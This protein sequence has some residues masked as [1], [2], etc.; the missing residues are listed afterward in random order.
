MQ[1]LLD[2]VF[3]RPN[4]M[5]FSPGWPA[6]AGYGR[7]AKTV[8]REAIETNV[9]RAIIN[10]WLRHGVEVITLLRQCLPMSPITSPPAAKKLARSAVGRC[11]AAATRH[12]FAALL[13]HV[14]E[15]GVVALETSSTALHERAGRPARLTVI[16]NVRESATGPVLVNAWRSLAEHRWMW[17]LNAVD[18]GWPVNTLELAFTLSSKRQT[19]GL[20]FS[21]RAQGL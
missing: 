6:S 14:M 5:W 13:Y 10:A 9:V 16:F 15:N 3:A 4:H 2:A 11:C 1:P 19:G 12:G 17:L 7:A 8:I 18:L 21:G 20:A